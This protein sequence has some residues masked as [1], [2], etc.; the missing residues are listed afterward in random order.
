MQDFG[1]SQQD[2]YQMYAYSK[3]YNAQKIVLIYPQ[4]DNL[5][6]EKVFYQSDDGVRVEVAFVDLRNPDES[7]ASLLR[8]LPVV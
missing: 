2:M 8:E 4:S 7:V 3:K 6:K 5:P 1:I